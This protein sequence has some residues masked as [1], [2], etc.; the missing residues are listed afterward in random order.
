MELDKKETYSKYLLGNIFSI[1]KFKKRK[2]CFKRMLNNK[3]DNLCELGK[4]SIG[5]N[6]V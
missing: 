1:K 3:Y 4:N 5:I 2:C 6:N